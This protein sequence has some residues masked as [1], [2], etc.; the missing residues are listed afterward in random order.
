MKVKLLMLLCLLCTLQ[1]A[2]SQRHIDHIKNQKYLQQKKDVDCNNLPGDNLSERICANLSF[3]KSDS[4]L[5]LIY[6][7]LLKLSKTNASK[8]M[9][10]KIVEM[11]LNWRKFRDSHCEIIYDSYENCGG[12]HQRAIS[13]LVCMKELTD[14]RIE[15]L[16]K[17][18]GQLTG[19]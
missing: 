11:Q 3:Q 15:E 18:Y 6:D 16:R 12:C 7:D 10:Q 9:H 13:Y 17:L 14:I 19:K 5:A 2:Y 1:T 4:L 8:D